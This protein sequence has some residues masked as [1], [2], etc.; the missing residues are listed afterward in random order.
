MK[1]PN[2]Y[3]CLNALHLWEFKIHKLKF[4]NMSK[5][6]V[7]H[8]VIEIIQT[9]MKMSKMDLLFKNIKILQKTIL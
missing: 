9:S 3:A 7:K 8:S 4:K 6:K 2:S 5:I 1:E